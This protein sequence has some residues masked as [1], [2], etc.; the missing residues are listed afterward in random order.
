MYKR[1]YVP[2][3]PFAVRGQVGAATSLVAITSDTASDCRVTAR[4]T[5]VCPSPPNRTDALSF[6]PCPFGKG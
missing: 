3:R 5:G 2:T 4:S 6:T 1:T